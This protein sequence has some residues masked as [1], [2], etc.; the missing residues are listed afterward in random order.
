MLVGW[1]GLMEGLFGL[2]PLGYH[3]ASLVVLG[4]AA[5]AVYLLCRELGLSP[6]GAAVAALVYGTH[7]SLA[8][9]SAWVSAVNS[10]LAVLFSTAAVTVALRRQTWKGG[11]AATTLI[12]LALGSREIA[13]I[14]AFG[15]LIM[16]VARDGIGA[17]RSHVGRLAPVLVPSAVFV[18]LRATLVD[19]SPAD[20]YHLS[21]GW[22]MRDNL[23]DLVR[24]ITRTGLPVADHPALLIWDVVVCGTVVVLA[25]R[26][27]M[28]RA[29]LLWALAALV[30]AALL[31]N[32]AAAPYYTDMA[33]VGLGL[34]VGLRCKGPWVGPAMV[35]GLLV[36]GLI[37]MPR[38][39][40]RLFQNRIVER[41]EV[42]LATVDQSAIEGNVLIVRSGCPQ[43][44]S[45]SRQGDLFR[46]VFDRPDLEVRFITPET[47]CRLARESR[48]AGVA[49]A[50]R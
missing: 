48:L 5:V 18:V 46:V 1:F 8:L 6:W 15:V 37:A 49:P 32:H 28:A 20:P 36:V 23:V 24:H 31:I 39:R 22:H 14:P 30:P 2:D 40:D 26:S 27:P 34:V 21:V 47:P 13:V 7:A 45:F 35:C 43:D 4:G 12:L 17:L 9:V 50:G 33:L 11:I 42:L 38:A 41:T 44:E 16:L 10:P 25:L 29:G 3:V 19:T